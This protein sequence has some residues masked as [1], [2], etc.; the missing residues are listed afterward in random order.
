MAAT[1]SKKGSKVNFSQEINATVL[2]QNIKEETTTS[3]EPKKAGRPSNG[4]TKKITLAIP[5]NL[6]EDME[7]GAS[8][9]YKGNKTAYINDLIKRD[10]EKNLE[11]YREFKRM[12]EE[13]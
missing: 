1:T 12:A 11:K 8:L 9:F 10:L 4:K 13:R 7:V 6:Y 5:I 2:N 3:T